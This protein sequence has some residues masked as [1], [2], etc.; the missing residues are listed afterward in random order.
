MFNSDL[1]F[2]KDE[3]SKKIYNKMGL[4]G[5]DIVWKHFHKIDARVEMIL[6]KRRLQNFLNGLGIEAFKLG[7]GGYDFNKKEK[8]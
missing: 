1:R 7:Y 2:N 8:I 3:L 6:L 5:E 4:D